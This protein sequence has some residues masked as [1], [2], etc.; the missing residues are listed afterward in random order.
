MKEAG[1]EH[2]NAVAERKDGARQEIEHAD[3]AGRRRPSALRRRE[4]TA[5]ADTLSFAPTDDALAHSPAISPLSH[6]DDAD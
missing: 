5:P 6:H 1:G 2:D 3:G 4:R